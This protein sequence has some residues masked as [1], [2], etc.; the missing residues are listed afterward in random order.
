MVTENSE[1]TD[2][3]LLSNDKILFKE[4]LAYPNKSAATVNNIEGYLMA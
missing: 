1:K 4:M 3:A 2:T